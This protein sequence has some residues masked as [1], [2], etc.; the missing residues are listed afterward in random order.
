MKDEQALVAD[1]RRGDV[2]AFNL[3]VREYQQLA[4]NVAYRILGNEEAATDAT[5]DA[6]LRAYRSLHQFHGE[7]FK[8]WLLRIVT[9]CCYD[10]LRIQ[11]RR[12]TTPI[13]DLIEDE[14]HTRVFEDPDQVPE[15]YVETL[16][17][18]GLIQQ[19]LDT[20]PPDQRMI[21]VMSDVEGMNYE[22]IAQA[23]TISLGT[24]KSRLSRGR[25]K[26]RNFLLRHR[27]L[28][29]DGMRLSSG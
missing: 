24:V 20:L 13:D 10:Q 28:L 25:A 1:A 19:G 14:E 9:N 7:S 27:E 11:Q 5:Q 21:V 2:A 16:E 12:P 3:L 4:Y 6:F 17:L 15:R 26:M 23:T 29:P 22:Q 8:A 18:D